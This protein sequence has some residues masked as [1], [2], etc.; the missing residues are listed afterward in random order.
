MNFRK[1]KRGY[2]YLKKNGINKSLQKLALR[3][4]NKKNMK[5]VSENYVDYILNNEPDFKDLDNQRSVDF[6]NKPK[7]SIVI[8]MYNTKYDFF[9]ELMESI[10]NQTYSNFEI[11]LADSSINENLDILKYINDKN[12]SRILYKRL[13]NNGGISLNTNEAI[14]MATGDYIAFCDHDDVIAPNA[15]FEVVKA[16]SKDESVDFIYSDEDI[17]EN[18]IRKNPHF[19]PD[20]SPDLLTSYNYICHLCVVKRELLNKVG[21]L[22]KEYDGAQDYDFVLRATEQ[23]KNIIHIPKILYHWR[24]HELSTAGDSSSKNYVFE[25]A[26]KAIEAHFKRL[27]IKVKVSILEEVGRYG[28]EYILDEEPKVSI[29]IPNKD[30][31]S[32]LKKCINSILKSTYKNYEIIVVENNSTKEDIFKYYEQLENENNNIKVVYSN[33]K[34]FNYPKINNIGIGQA[35]GEYLILLNNDTEIITNDW[36]ENMIGIC[37]RDDV[38]IVGAK[39]LYPDNTV[40]HAGVV[41][42][43]GSVAGHI[44][45]NINKD[46]PGYFSRANVINNFSAVTG[47]CLMIKKEVYEKVGGLNEK[48]AVAFN[49][50]DLC[51]KV[52]K[53]GY[54]VVYTPYAKLH[55]F[56]S[57]SRGAE[58]TKEKKARFAKEIDM[59]KDNWNEVLEKG[60]PYYNVNLRLDKVDFSI[61]TQKQER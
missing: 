39:L 53:E 20:F 38:G 15:L 27:N 46:D 10:L 32:D 11:C 26:K 50:I 40:Q 17:L 36:I 14:N 60:D 49:D 44:N 6:K 61:N 51:L 41:I 57:K 37:K 59:F 3:K 47:A 9:E 13:E 42:G 56:E 19:K 45:L 22:N 29:I 23:A 31:K 18:G 2:Y 58:D 8:P 28:V 12:D 16:I 5:N 35:T 33:I 55:H 30:S 21:M 25:A 43:I 24:A 4:Y 34:G 54:L 52:R 48:F 1:I 7:I